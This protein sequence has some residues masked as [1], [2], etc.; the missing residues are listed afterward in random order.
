MPPNPVQRYSLAFVIALGL[1]SGGCAAQKT[2]QQAADTAAPLAGVAE[3]AD[4]G[5]SYFY[6]LWGRHAELAANFSAALEAYEKVLI[7]DPA[8]D[9]VVKKIPLILLRLNRT[10]EAI[11]K[12]EE[13][14]E[15]H[16]DDTGSRMML[17]R[18]FIRQGKF[19][20]AAA[21][22]RKVNVLTPE[23]TSSLLLLSELYLIDG[24]QDLA[25]DALEEVVNIDNQS[26]SAHLLLARLLETEEDFTRAQHYYQQAL[27]INWSSELQLELADVFVRQNEFKPAIKLY[28]DLLERDEMDEDARIALIHVYLLQDK[29]KKAL[30]ELNRL[31]KMSDRPEQVDLAIARIY[32]RW[33]EYD[34]AITILENVI[35]DNEND[36]ARYLLAVLYFQGKQYE[37][38]L[39][40]L[41]PVSRDTE[42]YES[43]VFLQVRALRELERDDQAARVLETAIS[44]ETGRN[45]E[46]Y[47][48]L[49]AIY[50]FQQ[51]NELSR[52]VFLQ[53]IRAYPEDADLLYEYAIFLEDQNEHDKALDIMEQIIGLEPDHAGA[54]NFV[55]YTWADKNIHL[56]KALIY[57]QRAVELKPENSYILDSL[58]W[59]YYRLGKFDAAIT[60][61]RQAQT[62]SPDDAAIVEHLADVY[63]A[64]GQTA[65]ALETYRN[66]LELFQDDD[67]HDQVREKIRSLEKQQGK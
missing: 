27:E 54:L 38:V 53:G 51:E 37:A 50:Q 6:F 11:V 46:M 26:Y 61:L 30:S 62:L 16:P 1:F 35:Q 55:G 39:K 5:C 9:F 43:G 49:A 52:G 34:T 22:F 19:K 42:E 47:M 4:Y 17:A 25:R 66:I 29:E 14:L 58:G 63:L 36:E 40:N 45:T 60:T 59:V 67:G 33:K 3:E 8:A 41:Q 31:K 44:E 13:S 64:S 10:D 15:T 2:T 21:Q 20:E 7:C 48:L 23:D 12:L 28:R 57:I 56:D 18:V 24:K 32:A 65:D